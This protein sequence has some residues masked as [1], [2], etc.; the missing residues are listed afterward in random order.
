MLRILALYIMKDPIS[1]CNKK[2][3]SKLTA[4]F[5]ESSISSG[6]RPWGGGGGG[7]YHVNDRVVPQP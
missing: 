5:E 1:G 3:R 6:D 4:C 7:V 2:L